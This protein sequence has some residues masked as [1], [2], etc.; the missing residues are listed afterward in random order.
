MID[1][2][3]DIHE[4]YLENQFIISHLPVA[5][6][7]AM[8]ENAY[9]VEA[10]E[11]DFKTG[12]YYAVYY[13]AVKSAHVWAAI[14]AIEQYQAAGITAHVPGGLAR[15]IE[16]VAFKKS[17]RLAGA[18]MAPLMIYETYKVARQLFTPGATSYTRVHYGGVRS[19]HA[20]PRLYL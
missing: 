18:L 8:I 17:L 1:R 11:R 13:A 14:M 10:G 2:Y 20:V 6:T 16:N 4:W 7:I 9:K 15:T 5:N 12:V 3:S 19:F